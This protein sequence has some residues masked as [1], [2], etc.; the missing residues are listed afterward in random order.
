VQ[1]LMDVILNTITDSNKYQHKLSMYE[2][3]EQP[4]TDFTSKIQF[5]HTADTGRRK[6]RSKVNDIIS[7]NSLQVQKHA[8]EFQHECKCV[9]VLPIG[10]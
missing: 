9:Q 4:S 7:A 8:T 10:S 5:L 3:S 6:N 2:S 1:F